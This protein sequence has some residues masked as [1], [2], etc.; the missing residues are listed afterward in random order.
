MQK[1]IVAIDGLKF[2]INVKENILVA[3]GAYRRWMT[4]WLRK[5]MTD[6]LMRKL[7]ISLFTVHNSK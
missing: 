3:A 4:F 5:S 1:I 6:L 2:S 7:K